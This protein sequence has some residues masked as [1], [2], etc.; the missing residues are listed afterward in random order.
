MALKIGALLAIITRIEC[1][2]E[3]AITLKKKKTVQNSG[4]SW[5]LN[6]HK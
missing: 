1:R 5:Q 6:S 3:K 4:A 2:D